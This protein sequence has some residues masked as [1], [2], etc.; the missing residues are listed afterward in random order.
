[1]EIGEEWIYRKQ[2]WS[3]SERVVI[4]SVNED[5]RKRIDV[6]FMDGEKAGHIESAP[7]GRLKA[8]WSTVSDYDWMQEKW[9]SI[10]SE[11][12]SLD[13][14]IKFLTVFELVV[15]P[16]VATMEWSPIRDSVAIHDVSR[17]E[18][19]FGK[20]IEE[21][22]SLV[23]SFRHGTSV[24]LA[25]TAVPLLAK[26]ATARNP[27]PVL[28]WVMEDEARC[29]VESKRGRAYKSSGLEGEGGEFSAQQ[30][31]EEY[32]QS[33]RY[34]HEELRGWCGEE[35]ITLLERS[36]VA[37]MEAQRLTLMVVSLI[38]AVRELG[39]PAWADHYEGQL[40]DDVVTRAIVRPLVERPLSG[41][42]LPDVP[43]QKQNKYW[44]RSYWG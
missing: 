23:A 25:P 4:R 35:P 19:T 21:I 11:A 10:Y 28:E 7:Q 13:D 42:D 26:L 39:R 5:K 33:T 24:Y 29:R 27:L 1:M 36:L 16:Q 12:L 31:H 18:S 22:A 20:T 15:P 40:R 6:E 9:R 2:E 37:D 3:E 34:I 41:F 44:R 32:L 43:E 14:S 8:P 17:V 30:C 38:D